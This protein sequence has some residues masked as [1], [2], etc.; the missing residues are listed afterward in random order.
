[1]RYTLFVGALFWGVG[2][3]AQ[4]VP[5]GGPATAAQADKPVDVGPDNAGTGDSG[6][7]DKPAATA[8]EGP[9]GCGDRCV[10]SLEI[11][12]DA[13]S[14]R[15]FDDLHETDALTL[16]ARF[17]INQPIRQR[18]DGLPAIID[19]D[20]EI[21]A[22]VVL[23]SGDGGVNSSKSSISTG[24]TF[25]YRPV[26]YFTLFASIGGSAGFEQQFGG[27]TG[28]DRTL[29]AGVTWDICKK[30]CPPWYV[31]ATQFGLRVSNLDASDPA[32][33]ATTYRFSM[34]LT[35]NLDELGPAEG[36][37]LTR[38]VNPFVN[39]EINRRIYDRPDLTSGL[40]RR[41]WEYSVFGGFDITDGL[42]ALL[43]EHLD[44]NLQWVRIGYRYVETESNLP[45]FDAA[46][47][48]ILPSIRFQMTF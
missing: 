25:N 23:D 5:S 29:A 41:D 20:A 3:Q 15:P 46:T 21:A 36:T 22:G 8:A 19:V 37:N 38:F 35:W 30:F 6:P 18:P 44:D 31:P 1:M 7:L 43:P 11:T 27:D 39:V 13:T 45:A 34:G 17:R 4:G 14:A 24:L 9:G 10:V 40:N 26:P 48:A 47:R 28:F 12:P 32:K 16:T 2:A 33:D 42:K